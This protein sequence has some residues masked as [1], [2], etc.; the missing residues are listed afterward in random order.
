M[1]GTTEPSKEN[2][3][4]D[5]KNAVKKLY[6]NMT[7]QG[8]ELVFAPD[9]LW[10]L[11][12]YEIPIASKRPSIIN[13]LV[14]DGFIIR[15]GRTTRATTGTRK[16]STTTEYTFGSAITGE[17]S[18]P[19]FQPVAIQADFEPNH[20]G[21]LDLSRPIQWLVHG[22]PGSGK[23]HLLEAESQHSHFTLRTV[24]HPETRYSDFVGGLR[25]MQVYKIT[26][27]PNQYVGGV[28]ELP[29]EPFI[30]YTLQPGPLL[31]AYSLACLNP[32]KSV[33]LIIEELSR[34]S[35]SQAF[36][37]MLQLLDRFEEKIGT[38]DKGFSKYTIDPHPDI[39][40][41]L[42]EHGITSASTPA[43][44][45]RFPSNLYI[46]AT[47]NRADQNAKQLDAA[48]LRRW[49]RKYL[50]Y[51]QQGAYDHEMLKYG[52]ASVKWGD[53]RKQINTLL[54]ATPGIPEDKFIGPYLL[55]RLK[56]TDPEAIA[57]DL[58]GYLWSDVLK[59]RAAT[60]F[61]GASTYAELLRLWQLGNGKPI[62]DIPH[63]VN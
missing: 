50:S 57:D 15:T 31:Q 10:G 49:T 61:Q 4:D 26:D 38:N 36:G 27:E 32:E 8:A 2:S 54:E 6:N 45:M 14:A 16:G 20:L 13:R 18:Q 56:L 39:V 55:P 35:A 47:M 59:S 29:G 52:G 51:D 48:F 40:Q 28:A 9:V 34:A 24:F 41:W 33:I 46:W 19:N 17:E 21:V 22:C 25:P 30:I 37:D 3:L 7:E 62:G 53:L 11:C 5:A 44:K 12:S 42:I 23:S 60:F 63:E 1:Q 43:G 58:W